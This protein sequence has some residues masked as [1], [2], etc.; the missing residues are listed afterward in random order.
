MYKYALISDVDIVTD[1]NSEEWLREHLEK[2]FTPKEYKKYFG[3][4]RAMIV[5]ILWVD[6]R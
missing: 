6:D 3:N 4:G 1:M 5:K 2:D